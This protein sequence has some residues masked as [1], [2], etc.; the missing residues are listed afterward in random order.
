MVPYL[1]PGMLIHHLDNP[2]L[3]DLLHYLEVRKN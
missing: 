3:S 2:N 1:L